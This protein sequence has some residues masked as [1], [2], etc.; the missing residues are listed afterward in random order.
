M[1]KQSNSL[2]WF[3]IPVTD[4]ARAK[5][6]YQVAFSI[7]MEEMNM[8]GMEYAM[9]PY[10][11]GSGKLSGALVKSDI[12]KPSEEGV[13]IY[14]NGDPDLDP[15]LQRMESEHGRVIMGKTQISP[16][17]GYMAVVIDTEGNR[18]AL[19]SQH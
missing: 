1:D 14:L 11:M 8:N 17:V 3:E 6:F 2:N 15:V 18:I 10:E 9:F 12:S 13:L 16:E 19:H 7:H 5:H 4:M